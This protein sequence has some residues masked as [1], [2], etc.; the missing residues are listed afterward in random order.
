ME[1][2]YYSD[3][4]SVQYQ[5]NNGNWVD[6]ES[7]RVLPKQNNGRL[8]MTSLPGRVDYTIG[9]ACLNAPEDPLSFPCSMQYSFIA[10]SK[11]KYILTAPYMEVYLYYQDD[12]YPNEDD[13][14]FIEFRL[15]NCTILYQ[16]KEITG[17]LRLFVWNKADSGFEGNIW[18]RTGFVIASL[19]GSPCITDTFSGSA[20]I[21]DM[22]F[23]DKFFFTFANE[24]NANLEGNLLFRYGSRSSDYEL[25][26]EQVYLHADARSLEEDK[27]AQNELLR[28]Y[29]NW[30]ESGAW[31]SFDSFEPNLVIE[32]LNS[33]KTRTTTFEYS[34]SV[35]S[36]ELNEI[37]LFPNIK[38]F[39][40]DN[41]M[42]IVIASLVIA[43]I[44]Y[45]FPAPEKFTLN[46]SLSSKKKGGKRLKK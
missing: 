12:E 28:G 35:D 7:L 22:P 29:L 10:E 37:S 8:I 38:T 11:F 26:S 19:N 41:S 1:F 32:S 45:I 23:P 27:M 33:N 14:F 16:E 17:P 43:A 9:M 36:I 5:D 3:Y 18:S 39:F 44:T 24:I 40:M 13:E 15:E 21:E 4:G 31:F 25:F 46:F 34:C 30:D 2:G 42:N 6:A 20:S